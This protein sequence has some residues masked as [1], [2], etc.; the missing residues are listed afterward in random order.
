MF[1][2]IIWFPHQATTT[3]HSV[4]QFLLYL[5]IVCGVVGLL[6]AVL[7]IGFAVR[8]RR[9]P[10]DGVPPEMRGSRALEITWSIIPVGFFVSFF[11]WG[12]MIYLDAFRAP[13]DS[14]V[15]YVVA[16]QW[17]WKFQHP[18]G[19]REINTLHVP[20]GRSIKLVMTSE[21]VIHSFFVPDFRVHMDVLPGRYTSVWFNATRPGEYHLFCSQYCGTNHSKM[22]GRVVVM[23]PEEFQHWLDQH[24]EGGRAMEGQKVF[25]KY[26]CA[27]CH[28]GTGAA[29]A[30]DLGG[31]YGQN[32]PLQDGRMVPADEEYIRESILDPSAKIVAGHQNIMPTFRGQITEDEIIQFIAWLKTLKPGEMPRRVEESAPPKGTPPINSPPGGQP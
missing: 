20:V 22:I 16:K 24:A 18:G 2:E 23:Q 11:V 4:D 3:A 28:T 7:L 12:A 25:L 15:V 17:M 5:F 1:S 19:Q 8:F 21:D 32:V 14:T 29:R 30:P 26:R 6:V 10:G 27:S 13:D 9:R 31:L